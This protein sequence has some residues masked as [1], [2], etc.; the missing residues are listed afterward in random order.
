MVDKQLT[1]WT[2]TVWRFSCVCATSVHIITQGHAKWNYLTSYKFISGTGL[3][4]RYWSDQL[5]F[6]TS[7][8]YSTHLRQPLTVAAF[9]RS[10]GGNLIFFGDMGQSCLVTARLSQ[11]WRQLAPMNHSPLTPIIHSYTTIYYLG[12]QRMELITKPH[13]FLIVLWAIYVHNSTQSYAI[14][15]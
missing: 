15:P 12:M 5:Y 13:R 6:L 3:T 2:S 11:V 1:V 10:F 14:I 4:K 7:N 8:I 9:W